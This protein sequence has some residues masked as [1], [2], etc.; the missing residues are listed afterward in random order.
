[1]Q[2]TT[3]GA[4]LSM[5]PENLLSWLLSKAIGNGLIFCHCFMDEVLK[6]VFTITKSHQCV[7]YTSSSPDCRRSESHSIHSINSPTEY[8]N[9]PSIYSHS[10]SEY[11]MHKPTVVT[12][13]I[14]CAGTVAKSSPSLCALSE[15][16]SIQ[17][18]S[19]V[20]FVILLFNT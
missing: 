19:P 8:I 16:S 18:G 5:P 20:Y 13:L 14:A 11:H 2:T 9:I 3:P 17:D 10:L 12:V 15:T 6:Q 7:P 1:M 4:W